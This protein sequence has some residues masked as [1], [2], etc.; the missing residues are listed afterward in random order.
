MTSA[1]LAVMPEEAFYILMALREAIGEPCGSVR[2]RW[3]DIEWAATRLMNGGTFG[4][5]HVDG[6]RRQSHSLN[7]DRGLGW[8]MVHQWVEN[9]RYKP[10]SSNTYRLLRPVPPASVFRKLRP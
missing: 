8:L 7:Q 5:A 3:G 6:R 10:G 9:I 1:E 2:T 4:R